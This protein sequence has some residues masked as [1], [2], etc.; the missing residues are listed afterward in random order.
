M[1]RE[2]VAIAF[3]GNAVGAS[4]RPADPKRR[5]VRPKG[6]A[7]GAWGTIMFGRSAVAEPDGEGQARSATCRRPVSYVPGSIP[8]DRLFPGA[9]SPGSNRYPVHGSV[10]RYRGVPGSGSIFFRMWPTKTRR[11]S[12]C[13]P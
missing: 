13:S 6:C 7:A 1:P 2:R 10:S 11:Y 12:T 8:N 4:E 9:Y 3:F 5:S